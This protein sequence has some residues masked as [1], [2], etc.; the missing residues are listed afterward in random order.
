MHRLEDCHAVA[1]V[2]ARRKSESANEARCKIANDVAVQIGGNHH[3]ELRRVF[4]HLVRNVVNDQ[5]IRFE[6]RILFAEIFTDLLEE[7]FGE[8]QDVRLAR[9]GDLVA[10]FA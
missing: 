10:T 1:V 8:L 4:H 2:R 7:P 5:V 3:I 6:R 9:S